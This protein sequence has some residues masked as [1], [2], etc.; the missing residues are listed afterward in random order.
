LLFRWSWPRPAAARRWSADR[1]H[2]HAARALVARG[3]LRLAVDAVRGRAGD[4]ALAALVRGGQAGAVCSRERCPASVPWCGVTARQAPRS[5]G[6]LRGRARLPGPAGSGQH[7]L[8]RTV[9]CRRGWP[10]AGCSRGRTG[11]GQRSQ[12]TVQTGSRTCRYSNPLKHKTVN[13][14]WPQ[15]S[16]WAWARLARW[17]RSLAAAGCQ[18]RRMLARRPATWCQGGHT[19]FKG[20]LSVACNA[21]IRIWATPGSGC[22]LPERRICVGNLVDQRTLGLDPPHSRHPRVGRRLEVWV[23]DGLGNPPDVATVIACS[24]VFT[25]S[26]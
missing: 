10:P 3:R 13:S 24:L 19:L 1:F 9:R 22:L 18:G 4:T 7:S 11:D 25:R 12:Q 26:P 17:R 5:H 20:G 6:S 2:L 15:A 23:R 16:G 21:L 8:S 14:S